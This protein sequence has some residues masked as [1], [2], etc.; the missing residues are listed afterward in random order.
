MKIF[1]SSD[2]NDFKKKRYPN[3]LFF[4]KS[5]GHGCMINFIDEFKVQNDDDDDDDLLE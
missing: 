5:N 3:R 4:C 1:F 2:I